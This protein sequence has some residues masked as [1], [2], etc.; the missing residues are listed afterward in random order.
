MDRKFRP[1]IEGLRA[2]AALLVAIYHIW[3]NNISGGIDVFFVISGFLITT[4][5]LSRYERTGKIDFLG[6]I[7][8]LAK[9]L[10]PLA[11][12]VLFFTTIASILFLP[13]ILWLQTLKEIIAAALY[14]ENWQLARN[15]VDYLAQNNEASPVQHFWAMSV[16]GQFYF[17]W[18]ILLVFSIIVAKYILKKSVRFT[19]LIT[20]LCV[21]SLSLMYSIYL[22][23]RNQPWAYFDTFTRV[24]E[25]SL[26]GI[27]AI[28]ISHIILRKAYSVILGWLGL[29]GILCCGII[30]QVGS[31]FPG[32]AALWPTLCAVFILLA[33][34]QGGTLGVHQLLSRKP[35]V[36]FGSI[37]YGFYLWHWPILIFYNTLTGN[38][39]V[40]TFD[41]IIIITVSILLAYV[42][43][44]FIEKPYRT[45]Q[46]LSHFKLGFYSL[47]FAMPVLLLTVGW[48]FSIKQ[49]EQPDI[50]YVN[51]ADY[52]GAQVFTSHTLDEDV[53][54]SEEFSP[55]PLQVRN[56]L[57][58][59]YYD[60]CHQVKGNPEMI[61]C[62]YGATENWTYTMALVGGS[63]AL[64]WLPAILSFA[65][66][67]NI[68]VLNYTKAECRFTLDEDVT[69]DCKQWNEDVIDSLTSEKPDL[70]F[71][72]ADVGKDLMP[73]VPTGYLAMWDLLEEV[74]ID[75]FGIR[76]NP[77]MG[78]DV[79]YCV[80][81]NGKD[82]DNCRV[83]RDKVI[84]S[85]SPWSQLAEKPSN[86]HYTDLSD[87]I[88]DEDYCNP[89][90]GN[91]LVYRDDNHL[92]AS[93]STTL[94]PIVREY[95]M[96][97][98]EAVAKP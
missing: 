12:T 9:R 13:Q 62:E 68:K 39:Q 10:F 85:E 31:M 51:A 97:V 55:T 43:T 46:I 36:Q 17:I 80:D 57:P 38:E 83:E 50:I 44:K 27:V 5:L 4:S 95:L 18:P 33:G 16:Q 40:N 19:F 1:E 53:N 78:F 69:E 96:P 29:I 65:E 94:G 49:L 67:E 48:Y 59:P 64:Q 7:L 14:I 34:N 58:I 45:K 26:G 22:T 87:Y 91:V 77:W 37:S 63:H 6:F 24:W 23:E 28:I 98:L 72:N 82:L 86:V 21:F 41:G 90:E 79:P 93:Y 92:S 35:L 15:A 74:N 56:N 71:T 54:N 61:K 81:I 8:N 89:V 20:L 30:L 88:C 84:L 25:F 70:V 3:L 66:E 2:L 42:S 76:D 73:T 60:G 11:F 52:P 32:Y 47:C 75:V